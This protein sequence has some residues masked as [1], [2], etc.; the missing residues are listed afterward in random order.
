MALQPHATSL[1]EPSDGSHATPHIPHVVLL[2][3]IL[4][5]SPIIVFSLSD[6]KF[7]YPLYSP[8]LITVAISERPLLLIQDGLNVLSDPRFVV[9]LTG[10]SPS[11]DIA[12]N[13]EV[14]V[15]SDA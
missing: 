14:D 5:L 11:W 1:L 9:G 3:F 7:E 12:V 8:H 13:T 15:V 10:Y 6:F 4:Q 2:E